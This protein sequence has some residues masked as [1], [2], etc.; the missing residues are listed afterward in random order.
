MAKKNIDKKQ[1]VKKMR[2][3][4]K[5]TE[6][7]IMKELDYHLFIYYDNELITEAEFE[8]LNIKIRGEQ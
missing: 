3:V 8:K 5:A 7:A 2:E 6:W 4:F 1:I